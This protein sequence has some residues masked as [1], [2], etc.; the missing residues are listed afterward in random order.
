MSVEMK[1]ERIS[2]ALGNQKADLVIKN[3]RIINVFTREIIL[4]D[5]AICKDLIVGIG[6][7]SGI[8][9]IDAEGRYACPG[10]ID[11]HVH[12]ESSMACPSEFAKAILP[13][14]TTTIIADPHEITN[15][16][17]INGIHFIL[18][19][20]K[21]LPL[22][23]YIMVPSC[24]PATSFENNG[25]SLSAEVMEPLTAVDRVIGLGEVMDYVSVLNGDKTMLKKMDLFDH[26]IID[27]HSP[28]LT[29]NELNA[30]RAAGVLTDHECST[31]DEAL[32]RLRLGMYV[33][34]REGTAARNLETIVKGLLQK[35]VGFERCVFCTD[36]KH[37]EDI[38]REGHTSYNVKKAIACGLDPIDAIRAATINAAECYRLKRLGAI[39]PGYSADIILLNDIESFNIE[40]VFFR[41]RPLDSYDLSLRQSSP[42]EDKNVINTVRIPGIT[43]D[44]LRIRLNGDTATVIRILPDNLVTKKE[45]AKVKAEKGLFVADK[46]YS[47]LA[48]I[49]R[50]KS[51]NNTGLGIV[52]GFNIEN[53]AI[54]STVAHDSHNLIVIGDNDEDMILAV[55]EIKRANGGL[56]IISNGKVLATLELPIAGLM[57]DKPYDYVESKLKQMINIAW[58]IGVNRQIDPFIVLSFLALPVIPE[59][60]V[61]D[62]GLFDVCQ[63]KFINA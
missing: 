29:G 57:S 54:A 10:L 22:N 24:V 3:A 53:G 6:N 1:N 47:K 8:A 51:L 62:Q 32:E 38:K 34:I 49:E 61:T 19:Q 35:N 42:L 4:G 16:C 59:I 37:L 21:N 63:F 58:N 13:H 5:I 41:G 36:D 11:S 50:H 26:A 28:S 60:R 30:Y 9:E 52:K 14:G 48:V 45:I 33:Q 18:D 2:V 31:V 25:A 56:T 27:G 44:D 23:V 17:G 12:I 55:N 20:T 7:Y 46:E 15:V 43:R 39:A 40:K